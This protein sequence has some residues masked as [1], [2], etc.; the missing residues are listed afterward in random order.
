MGLTTSDGVVVGDRLVEE[1]DLTGPL[2]ARGVLRRDD[3][4]VAVLE[5]ARGGLVL[6]GMGYE[7]NDAAVITNVSADHL[8]LHGIHTLPEIAEVKAVIARVTRPDGAVVLNAQDELVATIARVVRA[9]VWWFSMDPS[10]PR[11]RRSLRG[12]GRVF[13]LRDEAIVELDADGAHVL[14]PVADVPA[15]LGGLARHNVANALAA[16]AGARALGA[17]RHEVAAGLRAYR[18]TAEQAPGRLNLYSDGRRTVIVDFAHNDAGLTVAL[19]TARSLARRMA[20][21]A[22]L[23]A[24]I[25]TAGDRPDDTLRAVGRVA[26][27]RSDALSI[28]ESLHYLRGRTR[29]GVIGELRTGIRSGGVD[30]T[31]VPVWIDEVTAVRAE[32]TDASRPMGGG[33]PGVLLVMCHEQRAGLATLLAALGFRPVD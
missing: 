24:V 8:D 5:T 19:D 29:D 10:L 6:R 7:S 12:G 31:R 15:T 20:P 3:V 30:P 4:D 16:A 27:Q 11:I 9:P 33:A 32:L 14:V 22:P 26:A 28:K 18:P 23:V 13:V 21:E 1:G 17:T 2:G 25:G